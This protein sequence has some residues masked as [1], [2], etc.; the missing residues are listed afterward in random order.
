MSMWQWVLVITGGWV[1]LAVPVGL[2]V[3]A[4]IRRADRE[5]PRPP[6]SPQTWPSGHKY[7]RG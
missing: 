5:T 3:G 7:R 1:V 2:G 6:R 4:V